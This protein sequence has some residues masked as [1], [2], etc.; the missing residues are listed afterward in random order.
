MNTRQ[1]WPACNIQSHLGDNTFIGPF[2]IIHQGAMLNKF[3]EIQR[4][5][6]FNNATV[7]AHTKLRNCIVGPGAIVESNKKYSDK[8]FV[9]NESNKTEEFDLK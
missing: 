1:Q 7:G 2:A 3:C 5:I 8:L 6:V 4:T 9:L